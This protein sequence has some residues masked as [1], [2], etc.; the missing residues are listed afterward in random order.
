MKTYFPYFLAVLLTGVSA[1]GL[2]DTDADTIPAF[3]IGEVTVVS[4]DQSTS[5]MAV[6]P[7]QMLDAKNLQALSVEQVSDAVKYFSGVTIKDY[8]GLGGMKTISVRSMGAQH[9]A[10]SYDGILLTDCQTGQTDLSRFNIENVDLISLSIGDGNNIFQPARAFASSGMLTIRSKRPFFENQKRLNGKLTLKYGSYGQKEVNASSAYKISD[11]WS[12]NLSVMSLKTR[13]D[14]DFRLYDG[15]GAKDYTVVSRTN[16]SVQNLRLESAWFGELSRGK[17]L[18]IRT[19]FDDSDRGLPGAVILYNPS[20]SQHLWDRT[21]FVQ[22]HYEQ[23]VVQN[24]TFQLNAKFNQTRQHYVNPDYLGSSGVEDYA[25]SQ[26]E[27]YLSAAFLYQLPTGLSYAF[28]VDGAVADMASNLKDFSA[29]TRY[30]LLANLS[31]KYVNEW[32]LATANV[33][34]SGIRE[35]THN[36]LS[37]NDIERLSPSFNLS[38][39]PFRAYPNLRLRAFWKSSFRQPS[40]NDLYYSAIGNTNLKP[41][42]SEQANVGI[43]WFVPWKAEQLDF[44][45]TI[46][47]FNNRITDKILA[48]P[49]RNM[50]IW[51]MVN[52]GKVNISGVDLN[53]EITK[54][55]SN[56][57]VLLAAWTHSYQLA[58]DLT[59]P[60]SKTYN[61]QIAYAP[62]IYG[63]GRL[64]LT[65]SSLRLGYALLYAG[66][67]YVTGQNIAQNDLSA[68]VDQSVTAEYVLPK[69]F[70]DLLIRGEIQNLAGMNYEIVRNFPMPGRTYRVSVRFEF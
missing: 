34:G 25:Y 40:F 32:M 55:W 39:Q 51:S 41:E 9:T 8:G 6:S 62:R 5:K 16:N 22:T 10:V 70:S 31:A 65:V 18:E 45:A 35:T 17:E 69:A 57:T 24:V 56:K 29:P 1:S 66:H 19:Y 37:A 53:F 26:K 68:Y 42:N 61:Q 43:T 67:R 15:S 58:L 27:G 33:L 64:Q 46:D 36:G 63:S 20:S 60:D 38:V 50:F 14:Y 12:V 2:A 3:R 44:N 23:Q 30:S 49:T 52:L 48:I 7:F 59:D 4:D 13:G 54:K 47:A 11:K 28:A 21:S